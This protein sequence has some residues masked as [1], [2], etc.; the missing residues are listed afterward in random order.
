MK[1]LRLSLFNL[2]KNKREAAAIV[3]LTMVTVFMLS[4]FFAN[5]SKIKKAFDE[6]FAESGSVNRIVIIKKSV[7]HSDFMNILKRD[8]KIERLSVNPFIFAGATDVRD[9]KGEV[10]SYNFLF[11]TERTERKIES[12]VKTVALSDDELRKLSHPIW[13]PV[14]FSI[15][16]GHK[17][18]ETF[19]IVKGGRDYPFTIAGFYETGLESSDG[20]GFKCILSDED[21]E[22]FSM[23][24]ET[25]SAIS[26]TCMGLCF[27]A[28]DDFDYHEFLNKCSE[29][30]SENLTGASQDLSYKNEKANETL[31]S[32]IFLMMTAFLSLI[33]MISALFMIRHK[34]SNDI[35]DQMQ[36]IGVFEALGYRAHEISLAYLYEYVVSAGLGCILG[37]LAAYLITPAMNAFNESVLGRTVSG[38]TETLKMLAASLASSVYIGV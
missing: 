35:E 25:D 32:D 22:L 33:T 1:I 9:G 30:S 18:G 31:F 27:D 19:T 17:A 34:I 37:A 21:Y 23:L 20:Y 8:Y 24:F 2:R 10:V 7:Y 16:K 28:E 14:S 36:Q 3:F 38:N 26:Y 15:S 12:F 13:L 5:G 29:V 6:S 11:A 4:I